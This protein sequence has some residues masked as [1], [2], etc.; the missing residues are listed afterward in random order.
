M[1]IPIYANASKE[2]QIT[3]MEKSVIDYDKV[4]NGRLISSYSL[5]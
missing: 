3:V 2:G 4:K 1:Y 5:F